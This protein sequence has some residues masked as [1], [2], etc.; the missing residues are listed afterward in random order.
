MI[1]LVVSPLSLI[2]C[3]N[4]ILM[5]IKTIYTLAYVIT[6]LQGITIFG[7]EKGGKKKNPKIKTKKNNF[8]NVRV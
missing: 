7:E 6:S 8:F 5:K 2:N 3:L 1:D 4:K